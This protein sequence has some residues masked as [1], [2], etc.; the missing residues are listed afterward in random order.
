MSIDFGTA[1]GTGYLSPSGS[2]QAMLSVGVCAMP[3]THWH[4][5]FWPEVD[6]ENGPL[7]LFFLRAT[8]N[9]CH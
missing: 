3:A 6:S 9:K 4:A 5:G 7:E 2:S 8:C 1:E